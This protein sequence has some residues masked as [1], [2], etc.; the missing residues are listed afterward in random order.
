MTVVVVLEDNQVT[1]ATILVLTVSAAEAGSVA[2]HG[3][4]HEYSIGKHFYTSTVVRYAKAVNI[5]EGWCEEVRHSEVEQL[6]SF[7]HVVNRVA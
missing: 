6:S 4:A 2:S 1:C 5:Y 7:K 3:S